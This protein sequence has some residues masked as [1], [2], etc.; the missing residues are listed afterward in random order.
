[1]LIFRALLNIRSLEEFKANRNLITNIDEDAFAVATNLK[2]IKLASNEITFPTS[3]R[4]SIFAN[5][6]N[7]EELDLSFNNIRAFYEDWFTMSSGI[8]L[9][10]NLSHNNIALLDVSY[11]MLIE[12][13]KSGS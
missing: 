4:F 13:I 3:K 7:L 5:C 6:K 9:H 11:F 10:L 1:M 2:K 8:F 12:C